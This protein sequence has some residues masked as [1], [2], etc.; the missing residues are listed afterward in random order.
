MIKIDIIK[1]L[2]VISVRIPSAEGALGQ[3][4]CESLF[5]RKCDA[6]SRCGRLA[7][8]EGGCS[9]HPEVYWEVS[10]ECIIIQCVYI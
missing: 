10:E 8:P 2:C 1:C 9:W 3:V 4:N 7:R 6:S 5:G